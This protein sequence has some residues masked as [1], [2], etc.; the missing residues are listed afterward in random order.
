MKLNNDTVKFLWGSCC[1]RL[2]INN[3]VFDL[4]AGNPLWISFTSFHQR[5]NE[6]LSL[7]TNTLSFSLFLIHGVFHYEN[8][9][10]EISSESRPWNPEFALYQSF[11]YL[12]NLVAI[13]I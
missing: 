6:I 9:S 11:I 5:Q 8:A 4:S 3:D 7:I 13:G 2:C 1:F 12:S 10:L